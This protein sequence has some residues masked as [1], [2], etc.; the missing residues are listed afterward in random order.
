MLYG[1]LSAV[2]LHAAWLPEYKK[3][4]AIPY[5]HWVMMGL[6]DDGGYNDDAYKLTLQGET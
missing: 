3:E 5:L 1:A 2:T 4:D 6:Y